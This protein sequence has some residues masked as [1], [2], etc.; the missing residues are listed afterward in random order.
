MRKQ[1]EGPQRRTNDLKTKR[2]S[3]VPSAV[4]SRNELLYVDV[5]GSAAADC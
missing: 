4:L 2:S 1:G 3:V 5:S